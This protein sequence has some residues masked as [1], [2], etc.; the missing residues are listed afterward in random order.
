MPLGQ[1]PPWVDVK[2]SDFVRAASGGATAGI[3]AQKTFAEQRQASDRLQLAYD[4]LA[5]QERRA[6]EAAQAK[7]EVAI[8]GMQMRAQQQDAALALR[9]QQQSALNA[10]RDARLLQFGERESDLAEYR[11]NRLQQFDAAQT[12]RELGLEQRTERQSA[13][14]EYRNAMLDLR[15][16]QMDNLAA[17]REES[18][19]LREG[20]GASKARVSYPASDYGPAISGNPSDPEIVARQ[21]KIEA[22]K[23]AE[24]LKPSL[25]QRIFGGGGGGTEVQH[26]MPASAPSPAAGTGDVQAKIDRANV[27]REINPDWTKEEILEQVNNEFQ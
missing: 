25:W 13:L 24:A 3:A 11:K 10:Y 15:K 23:A 12:L 2:P 6:D 8:M 20:T 27:L 21:Q 16:E 4:T 26:P 9:E 18:L 5:S 1:I 14:D 19:R 7:M 22:D 17:Y